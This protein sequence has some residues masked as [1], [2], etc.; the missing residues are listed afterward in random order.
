MRGTLASNY[1]SLVLTDRG[2]YTE[3]HPHHLEEVAKHTIGLFR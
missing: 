3:E 2:N 1:D